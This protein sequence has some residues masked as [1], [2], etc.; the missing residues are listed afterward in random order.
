MT[1]IDFLQ[2]YNIDPFTDVDNL[3]NTNTTHLYALIERFNYE[4]INK[5][6]SIGDVVECCNAMCS[7]PVHKKGSVYCAFHNDL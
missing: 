1:V 2:K 4:V 7:E 5:S 6:D 3:D